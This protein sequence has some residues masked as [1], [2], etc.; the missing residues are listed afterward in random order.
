[1][2]LTV[3]ILFLL[4]WSIS[5]AQ[6]EELV[7]KYFWRDGNDEH[8]IEYT[9]TINQ[10][11]TFDFHA[12]DYRENGIPK[13][14]H[15][16]GKGKYKVDGKVLTFVTDME[17]DI[18]EKYTLDFSNSKARF[19]VKPER[20]KTDRVVETGLLFFESDIFWINSLKILKL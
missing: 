11:G 12:Y 3:N 15:S 5:L 9:L 2:N 14:R 10:D 19:I 16:Y 4:V 6:S 18:N 7:G 1:M 17:E 13:E 20:D 8:S